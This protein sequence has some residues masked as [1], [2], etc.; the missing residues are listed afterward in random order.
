M[1]CSPR[2]SRRTTRSAERCS[3]PKIVS[4]KFGIGDLTRRGHGGFRSI[5]AFRE[6]NQRFAERRKVLFP[7]ANAGAKRKFW[8][9]AAYDVFQDCSHSGHYPQHSTHPAPHSPPTPPRPP[10]PPFH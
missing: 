4:R 7:A 5:V 2:T 3:W 1:I 9:L 6:L 8:I 10:H